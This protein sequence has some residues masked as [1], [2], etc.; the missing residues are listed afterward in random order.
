MSPVTFRVNR[1]QIPF[2]SDVG[3]LSQTGQEPGFKKTNQDNCLAFEKFL[4]HG[5]SLYAVFDGH[6]PNG[7][8]IGIPFAI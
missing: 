7:R 8:F 2:V 4:R 6:G 3:C 1:V 5:Q